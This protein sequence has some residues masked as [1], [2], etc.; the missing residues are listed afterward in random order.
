M[1]TRREVVFVF[2]A[3]VIRP[4]ITLAQ[5]AAPRRIGLHMSG[6]PQ[7]S[8]AVVDEFKNAM[9][10]L[11]HVE[12]RDIVYD[13]R[14]AENRLERLPGLASELVALKPAAI[15]TAGSPGVAACQQA[16]ASVPIVFASAGDPIRQGF[17]QSYRRPGGNITGVAFNEEINKKIYEVVKDLMPHATR[18]AVLVNVKNQAQKHHIEDLPAMAK[19]LNFQ[20][21]LVHATQEEEL[22]PAF[23]EAV[24]AKAQAL[25][26]S[27]V[28][29]FGGLAAQ[30]IDLQNKYH[31]PTF[32]GTRR[33]TESGSVASYSF[34]ME[35]NFRRSAAIVDKILKGQS[36]AEIPVELPTQYEVALNLKTAKALGIPVPPTFLARVNKVIE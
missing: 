32:S 22:E 7:T 25:V 6:T 29:P 30:I 15:I 23:R 36:P 11:G 14:W 8:A 2:A 24:K 31:L 5:T 10:A 21:I 3:S 9:K 34:P 4:R 13:F 28:A 16:T 20:P 12:G 18:I 19:G 1:A 17:I 33:T 35:E 26:I 27:T